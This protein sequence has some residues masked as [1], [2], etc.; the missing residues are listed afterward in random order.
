MFQGVADVLTNL[1]LLGG[2]VGHFARLVPFLA[3]NHRVYAIDLLGFG[4][5]DKPANTEYGPELWADLVCGA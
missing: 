2:N 5:S 1:V 4:A 3:E